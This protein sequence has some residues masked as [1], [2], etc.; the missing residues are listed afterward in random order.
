MTIILARIR[1]QVQRTVVLLQMIN[2]GRKIVVH[3]I[4]RVRQYY[5]R[6]SVV[7]PQEIGVRINCLAFAIRFEP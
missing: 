6:K 3:I 5:S 1:L 4:R 2:N 7:R